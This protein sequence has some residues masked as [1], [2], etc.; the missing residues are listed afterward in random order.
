MRRDQGVN[1]LATA[2]NHSVDLSTA[3]TKVGVV[4]ERLPEVVDG[5]APRLGTRVNKNTYFRLA[6]S[7]T[8]PQRL[9]SGA[10]TNLKHAADGIEQPPV[11]VD[12]LLILRLDDQDDL[13]GNEVV[14]IVAMRHHQ[15]RCRIDRE[16][17]RVLRDS[18]STN[19]T[20]TGRC[21]TSKI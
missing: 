18:V 20:G 9:R 3:S 12:L 6:N 10:I 7:Q 5:L 11:R 13:D 21:H 15:L 14:G 19:Q 1:E 2:L 17:G 4:V 16:L 8:R